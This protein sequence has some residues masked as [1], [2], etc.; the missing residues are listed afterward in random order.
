MV[1]VRRRDTAPDSE[2]ELLELQTNACDHKGQQMTK[3]PRCTLAAPPSASSGPRGGLMRRYRASK[4]SCQ[5]EQ[6][7][8]FLPLLAKMASL[9]LGIRRAV[10]QV[11]RSPF[12]CRQCIRQQSKLAAAP[13][14][15]PLL[16]KPSPIVR[17]VRAR[18]ESTTSKPAPVAALA[19][20]INRFEAKSTDKSSS[21][22]KSSSFPETNSKSVGIFLLASATSVFG[23]V[24]F[25]GLTRLTE[26]G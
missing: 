17:A 21:S 14:R 8:Q 9:S 7:V 26:S 3:P 16:S 15:S 12:V 5:R 4:I 10:A 13:S 23:I 2:S 24:V 22:S 11:S 19:D 18:Y 20:E 1:D 6:Q 25:G